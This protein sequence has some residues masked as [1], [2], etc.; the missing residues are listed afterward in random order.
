M[1]N[2]SFELCFLPKEQKPINEIGKDRDYSAKRESKDDTLCMSLLNNLS[3]MAVKDAT[4]SVRGY[5]S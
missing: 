2:H 1:V 4:N 5:S 3:N